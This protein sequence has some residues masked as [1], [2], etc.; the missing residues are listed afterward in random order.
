LNFQSTTKQQKRHSREALLK[1]VA[2]NNI[3][4]KKRNEDIREELR[5]NT[6]C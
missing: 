6:C 4:D 2:A 1:A 3:I 5:V